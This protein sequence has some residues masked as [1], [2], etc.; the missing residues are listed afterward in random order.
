ML[1]IGVMKP[2][3]CNGSN[4]NCRYCS[5]SGYVPD[6]NPLPK[7]VAKNPYVGMKPP[8]QP[9]LDP[10]IEA[11]IFRG[12]LARQAEGK[13]LEARRAEKRRNILVFA[14]LLL[15]TLLLYLFFRWSDA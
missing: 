2:C 3:V 1:T 11:E 12:I 5:G 15:L 8:A 13:K 7:G 6:D 4:D 9:Q 10:A 14:S